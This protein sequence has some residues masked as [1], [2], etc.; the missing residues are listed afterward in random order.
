[1]PPLMQ[2]TDDIMAHGFNFKFNSSHKAKEQKSTQQYTAAGQDGRT[3]T[4]LQWCIILSC[5]FLDQFN[6][7]SV[8][9][10]VCCVLKHTPIL[11]VFNHPPQHML[12]NGIESSQLS[13]YHTTSS[14]KHHVHLLFSSLQVKHSN[15]CMHGMLS[16]KMHLLNPCLAPCLSLLTL[17]YDAVGI[18]AS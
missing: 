15:S 17:L 12:S 3:Q 1:M 8:H 13:M 6:L 2:A 18:L 5:T 16:L 9:L 10:E 14:R 4:Y 11:D 7:L